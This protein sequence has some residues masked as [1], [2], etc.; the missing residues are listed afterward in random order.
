MVVKMSR[1][2]RAGLVIAGLVGLVFG[3][4]AAMVGLVFGVKALAATG[5]SY[6]TY[7]RSVGS[8][9][10]NVST[11]ILKKA[12]K[13]EVPAEVQ[14]LVSNAAKMFGSDSVT[15]AD[16]KVKSDGVTS[17]TFFFHNSRTQYSFRVECVW[18][19]TVD[20]N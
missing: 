13:G 18:N 6:V 10:I 19:L 15:P 1:L 2:V 9:S 8:D 5:A 3:V 7:C 11:P 12:K 14:R 16:A 20:Y 4:V 17:Q